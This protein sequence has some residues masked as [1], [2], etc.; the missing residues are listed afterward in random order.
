MIRTRR[1]KILAI[2]IGTLLAAVFLWDTVEV[3]L[4]QPFQSVQ[5]ELDGMRQL[6]TDLDLEELALL[7]ASSGL[8]KL[9]RK[10]LP[11]DPGT[12][13]T[14]YQE[15]L[16]EELKQAGISGPS[17]IPAPALIDED[18]GHRLTFS[19]EARG[20][21]ESVTR[22]LDRFSRKD[23]LHRMTS[24]Q[25]TSPSMG[26]EDEVQATISIEALALA[27]NPTDELPPD[28][29]NNQS[30]S[31]ILTSLMRTKNSFRKKAKPE[32]PKPKPEEFV[33]TPPTPPTPPQP[34]KPKP[35]PFQ[36]ALRF[37]GSITQGGERMA[38]F[39]DQRD[40]AM[41]I[42]A[43]EDWI[44]LNDAELQVVQIRNDNVVV[45][46]QGRPFRISL[47]N[48]IA[49]EMSQNQQDTE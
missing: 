23:L 12:A 15:W 17:V 34:P 22:F 29:S 33:V 37:T 8:G 1:E 44:D 9:A 45:E 3:V 46:L 2:T 31:M 47:G 28:S 24:L 14:V 16:V 26:A 10:S 13:T 25:I 30:D 6:Q 32:P 39:V 4:L 40:D 43:N 48:T 41:I 42:A 7:K 38:L 18:L 19:V 11:S 27:D 36:D 35:V 5:L 20:T 49:E 21:T